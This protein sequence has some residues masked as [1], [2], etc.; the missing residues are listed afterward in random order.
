MLI[1][2]LILAVCFKY[3]GTGDRGNKR[4]GGGRGCGGSGMLKNT[5]L[6][7]FTGKQLSW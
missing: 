7:H 6:V 4:L 5:C 3:D 1:L 2:N